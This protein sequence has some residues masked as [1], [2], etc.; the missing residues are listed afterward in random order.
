MELII[1]CLS[2]KSGIVHAPAVGA[3]KFGKGIDILLCRHGKG[4][5]RVKGIRLI[6]EGYLVPIQPQSS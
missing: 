1:P 2:S 4:L 3:T 6:V 5:K